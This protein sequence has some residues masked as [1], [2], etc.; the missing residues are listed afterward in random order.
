MFMKEVGSDEYLNGLK[1]YE[2]RDFVLAVKLWHPLA[3]AGDAQAQVGVAIC[4]LYGSVGRGNLIQTDYPAAIAWLRKAAAQNDANAQFQLGQCYE[5][6]RGVPPSNARAVELMT[7]AA[8]H[9]HTF[10]Q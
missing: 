10:S 1:A 9:G 4:L 6:G 3:S 5:H 2:E 7:R 8:E